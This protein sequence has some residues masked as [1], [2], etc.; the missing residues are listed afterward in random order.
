MY[1]KDEML[2]WRE[3]VRRLLYQLLRVELEKYLIKYGLVDSYYNFKANNFPY[4]FVEKRELKPKAKVVDREY[5]YQNCFLVVFY[6]GFLSYKHKKYIRFLSDN[7]LVKDNVQ[8]LFDFVLNQDFRQNMKYF[9]SPDFQRLFFSLLPVDYA[10]LLQGD[11]SLMTK[12]R[13]VLSHFHVKLDWPISDASENLAKYLRYISKDLFER[14]DK[15]A[16]AI[17][18]K[19]FEYYGFH[20]SVGG[21]RSAAVVAS[22]YLSQENLQ[23]TIFV[24]SQESREMTRIDNNKVLRYVL[25][26]LT[27]DDIAGFKK[28]NKIKPEQFIKNYVVAKEKEEYVVVFLVTYERTPY[29]LPPLDGKMRELNTDYRWLTVENQLIIPRAK[30]LNARPIPYPVIYSA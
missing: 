29:S 10:L 6:E 19:L 5:K 8:D 16:E 27:D 25:M 1:F 13:Y 23:F 26:K 28:D 7:K 3:K 21:R 14:G 12:T 2:S 11:P 24:S 22:Q 17:Q 15:Y 4:P 30:A 20:H 18:Q 9:D